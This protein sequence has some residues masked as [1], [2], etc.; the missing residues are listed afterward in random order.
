MQSVDPNNISRA[1]NFEVLD[2][3]HNISNLAH[4]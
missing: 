2:L 3:A 4:N 1:Y